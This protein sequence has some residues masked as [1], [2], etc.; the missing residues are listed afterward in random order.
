M[1]NP[2]DGR[3][4]IVA[5]VIAA[6]ASGAFAQNAGPTERA[7]PDLAGFRTVHTA[8]TTRIS[9]PPPKSTTQ[10]GFLGIA[11]STDKSGLF[12]VEVAE[13]SPA[14]RAGIQPGD[15]IIVV[16]S[17]R[18]RTPDDLRDLLQARSPGDK[19]T[20]HFLRDGKALEAT[21]TLTATSK[22]MK[23][24]EE[25]AYLGLTLGEPEGEGAPV[26][27][28]TQR[29]PAAEAGIRTGDL[30]LKVDGQALDDP[31]RLDVVLNEKEPGDALA[32]LLRR[33][34]EEVEVKVTL[35]E[36]PNAGRSQSF[37][38]RNVWR[39]DVFRLAVIGIEYPDVKHNEQ[40]RLEDWREQLFSAGTYKDKR[41]A[42]GQPVYGSLNDF[43][44]EVSNGKL[45][46][47]GKV[48]DWVQV[49]KNRAEYSEGTGTS[50]RSRTTLFNEVF[51]KLQ[52]REGENVLEGYDGIF[53][54]YAGA[55]FQT[56]RG[57][58]YWPHRSTVRLGN[59]TYPYFIMQEGGP[60]MSDISVMAHEFGHMLGLPDLYARPENPGSE[61]LGVW[62]LMSNQTGGGRPQ[63]M[64]AWCKE[65]LGWL[66]PTVIDPTVP[67]KLILGPVNGS[68]VECFKVL[69]RPDGSE[70]LLL[71]NRRRAGFDSSL[72]AEG[73][74][75][76]HVV[77]NRPVLQESHGVDGPSGP[78]SYG[79][80]VPYPSE[81]NTMFTPFTTPSSKSQLGGGLPV[82]ITN[83]RQLP[84]GRVTFY[85]GYQFQ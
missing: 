8:L 76:W 16:G 4:W 65:Q 55:R 40:V 23:L 62:C 3:K 14:M 49:G 72:P 74:L 18:P 32:I 26:R 53:F 12:V 44:Q 45:R 81:S 70:Y 42:T 15:I 48:F 64:G 13:D 78:R 21:A 68:D 10:T 80:M 6:L 67:Q 56:S 19:L 29:S 79:S 69:I 36:D 31:A 7:A 9:N 83:I 27:R 38:P 28:V 39:R 2:R 61:G 50:A 1:T 52:E 57:G 17:S 77:G 30:V 84:D 51:A 5:A 20:V 58:L 43:Y 47:E 37:S 66:K 75:I 24:N 33:G 82:Y 60:R 85:I 41:N 34:E 71:E 63:H 11:T 59:R 54:L 46:I 35:A 25:R 73:L 22:P